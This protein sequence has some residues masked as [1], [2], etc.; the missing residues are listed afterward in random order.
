MAGGSDNELSLAW[1]FLLDCFAAG[2]SFEVVA[3]FTVVCLLL[4]MS[5]ADMHVVRC[6]IVECFSTGCAS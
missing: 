4:L 6:T 3:L 2:A 1:A 5:S